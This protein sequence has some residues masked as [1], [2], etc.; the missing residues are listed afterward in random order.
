MTLEGQTFERSADDRGRISLPKSKAANKRFKIKVVEDIDYSK[1]IDMS[2]L[3]NWE[4][5]KPSTDSMFPIFSAHYTEDDLTYISV[6]ENEAEDYF[7]V[8][9]QVKSGEESVSIITLPNEHNTAKEAVKAA[10]Q[11]MKKNDRKISNN[12]G[13]RA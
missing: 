3:E 11:W 4:V 5:D 7:Y 10:K 6:L 8:E 2:D 13:E 9:G 12:I 1:E